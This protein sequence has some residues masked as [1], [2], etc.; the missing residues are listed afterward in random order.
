MKKTKVKEMMK[1]MI[2]NSQAIMYSEVYA[3]L[4]I[5]EKEYINLI[6]SK[7]YNTIE[8][9][10]KKDYSPTYDLSIPLYK[11][12]ISRKTA[13]FLCLLHY[14]YWCNSEEEKAIID[15]FLNENEE[16]LYS[17]GQYEIFKKKEKENTQIQNKIENN[18][19]NEQTALTVKEKNGIFAKII[20]FFKSLFSDS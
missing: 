10:R 6:P 3:I 9:D 11:Q 2:Y 5:L 16:K 13:S 15:K 20:N 17:P 7:I 1:K 19:Y 12:N 8:I 14:N 4:N 18:G